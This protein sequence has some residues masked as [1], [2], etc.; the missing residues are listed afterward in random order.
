MKKVQVQTV[1]GPWKLGGGGA[2]SRNFA[3]NLSPQ[4]RAFGRALKTEKVKAPHDFQ[5]HRGRV[6]K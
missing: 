3:I 4:C 6:Y 5:P 2:F 1:P